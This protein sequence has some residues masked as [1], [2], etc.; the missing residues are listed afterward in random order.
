MVASSLVLYGRGGGGYGLSKED[1]VDGEV[2]SDSSV[3]DREESVEV[4]KEEKKD[5]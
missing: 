1:H 4:K 2:V 5:E 3:K